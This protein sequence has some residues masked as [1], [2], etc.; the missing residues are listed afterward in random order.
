ME[1]E[2][3]GILALLIIAVVILGFVTL[4]LSLGLILVYLTDFDDRNP[5]TNYFKRRSKK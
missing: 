1:S 5:L 4:A 3:S 2:L